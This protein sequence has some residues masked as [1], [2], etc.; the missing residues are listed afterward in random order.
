MTADSL[1]INGNLVT[2]LHSEHVAKN[3]HDKAE[4]LKVEGRG[5]SFPF[6]NFMIGNQQVELWFLPDNK[7]AVMRLKKLIQGAQKSVRVAMFTWTRQDLAKTV[8]NAA[9]RGVKTE[10]VIDH[11]AGKGAGAKIVK[12]LK[13]NNIDVYLSTG[14]PLL[15]HKFLYIDNKYLVNGSAN[16]TKAA[17]TQNDDCFIVIHDLTD[18]QNEQMETLWNV[19][20][21]ESSPPM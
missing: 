4:T 14:T 21:N 16:W 15:H 5:D 1:Y 3:I 20:L 6:E 12:L 18:K 13:D 8:I 17:F 2:A 11:C 9:K 7:N 19:I 10:V